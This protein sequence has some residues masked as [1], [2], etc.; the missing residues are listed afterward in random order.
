MTDQG[1][2]KPVK[3]LKKE[4]LARQPSRVSL[5]KNLYSLSMYHGQLFD[6]MYL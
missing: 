2:L 1:V 6:L 3:S 4:Y 5:E